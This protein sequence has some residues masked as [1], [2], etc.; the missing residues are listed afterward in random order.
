MASFKTYNKLLLPMYNIIVK[1]AGETG[2]TE[3]QVEYLFNRFSA[4]LVKKLPQIEQVVQDVFCETGTELLDEHLQRLGS[5]IQQKKL[6]GF[7]NWNM[8][9]MKYPIYHTGSDIL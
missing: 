1:L 7:N 5:L 2:L 3:N 4:E 8:P 6:S 9:E